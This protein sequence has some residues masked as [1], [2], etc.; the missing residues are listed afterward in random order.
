MLRQ[1]LAWFLFDA[2]L[3]G[4]AALLHWAVGKPIPVFYRGRRDGLE[5]HALR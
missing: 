4:Y 5:L 1:S 3:V 2:K